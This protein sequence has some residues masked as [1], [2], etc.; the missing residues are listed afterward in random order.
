ML[1]LH[2]DGLPADLTISDF[3]LIERFGRSVQQVD[4]LSILNMRHTKAETRRAMALLVQTILYGSSTPE[5]LRLENL[6]FETQDW[7]RILEI[8]LE[9]N[10]LGLQNL[11]VKE[12]EEL[13][14]P[15]SGCIFMMKQ[16]LSMQG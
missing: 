5:I 13:W 6:G 12:N 8:L 3:N 14:D 9:K 10:C 16:L 11:S 2:L 7:E 15:E 1:E 4:T